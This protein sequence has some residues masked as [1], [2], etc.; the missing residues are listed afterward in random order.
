MARC[1]TIVCLSL[2]LSAT[3]AAGLTAVEK[4]E[5]PG[6]G[7]PGDLLRISIDKREDD[8][9]DRFA[10]F[11]VIN[12]PDVRR[13][14]VVTGHH[15]SGQLRD[16]THDVSY[17]T[18]PE[19]IVDVDE[20]GL[21]TPITDGK[22][23]VSIKGPSDMAAAFEIEVKHTKDILPVN[24]PNRVV[25]IFTKLGCNSGGCHGKSGGQN[26]FSLSLLGFYPNEDYEYLVVEA[27]GRRL[28][29]GAPDHSLILRK[30]SAAGT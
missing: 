29:P 7:D 2:S 30:A 24:F 9:G 3:F 4:Q 5:A 27:R 10:K 21:V 22:T 8:S 25:P 6:L 19:G 1:L 20:T 14:I 17:S 12:G 28:F 15:S 26:G 16:L 18:D 11:A 23:T 13:Q